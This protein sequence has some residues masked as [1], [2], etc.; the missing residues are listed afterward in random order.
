MKL[1]D[2]QSILLTTASTRPDLCVLPAPDT[3]KVRGAALTRTLAALLRRGL[4]E[5]GAAGPSNTSDADTGDGNESNAF[6]DLKI[7]EAG[8]VAIGVELPATGNRTARIEAVPADAERAG[9]QPAR[10]GGKLGQLLESVA[11]PAGATL[12]ELASKSGW[13]PHTTRAAIT[14]LRQRGYDIQLATVADR[15]SYRLDVTA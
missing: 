10:P 15:R 2:T 11:R 13:L 5:E 4:I 14:R 7:T 8:L 6:R 12:D 3:I 9:L 1:T